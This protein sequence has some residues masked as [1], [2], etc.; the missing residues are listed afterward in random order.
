MSPLV[1]KATEKHMM[2]VVMM[3]KIRE[4]LY[5]YLNEKLEKLIISNPRTGAE[6]VKISLR[7]RRTCISGKSLAG[8][9]GLAQEYDF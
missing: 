1:V 7:Q 5:K 3:E 9:K 8:K 4:L 6:A 2:M